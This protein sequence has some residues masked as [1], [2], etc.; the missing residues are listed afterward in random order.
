MK[1]RTLIIM[2]AL[3][4]SALS[5]QDLQQ[6]AD[7]LSLPTE[8]RGSKLHIPSVPGA[9]VS[10]LGADYEQI[11]SPK[12]KIS[13]LPTD[14]PVQVS[15]TLS[16]NGQEAVS[17][18]Y[19]IT[20][21]GKAI[22]QNN[23][24][25]KPRIIPDILSWQGDNGKYTLG[26][27]IILSAPEGPM[28]RNFARELETTTGKKVTL[29]KPGKKNDKKAHIILSPHM[30]D[31]LGK[32]GYR[33]NISKNGIR[34]TAGTETGLFWS[35]RTLL[36]MLVQDSSALPYGKILD[37][38]RYQLRGFMLDIARLPFPMEYLKE[39]VRL[40][41]WYKMNDLHLTINN[42]YIFHEQYVDEGKDPFKESYAAFRLQSKV[43]G[44]TATDLSYTKR[45]F[46]ELIDF[47]RQHGINIVPEFDAPGHALS[48]TRVRP[49]LIYK[50]EMGHA[51]R[52]CEML[53]AANPETLKFLEGIY[54]E[55]LLPQKNKPAVFDGCVMHI[56]ADE[57][58]GGAEHY[59]SFMDGL[60][61]MVQK[62]GYTPR[63]WGSLSAKRGNTP[64]RSEGVQMNLWSEGWSNAWE[65][66]KAGYDV[67]NTNDA[68]L[69]IVPYANYY[70]ADYN[71]KGLYNNWTPNQMY[72][73]TLPAGH[74]QLIGSTFAVWNDMIDQKYNG[75]GAWD[76]W[77]TISGTVD[78]LAQKMWGTATAPTTFEQHREL[79]AK[80][81]HIPG[82]DP[83]FRSTIT[84]PLSLKAKRFEKL[85]AFIRKGSLG[86][87][88]HLTMS[89]EM[90]AAPKNGEEQ[91]LLQSPE[92]TLYAA[93]KDGTIGF[94]R[95]DSMSF[96]FNCKLPVGKRT[97]LELIGTMGK[98]QLLIDGQP[99]GQ[100]TLTRF[101]KR[102]EG[103]MNTFILPLDIVG[104]HFNGTIYSMD[105]TPAAPKQ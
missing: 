53:D 22:P 7:S 93:M 81:N 27:E 36:Q 24:N 10:L 85:P 82:C 11:I 67:I 55:Y 73:Q 16:K 17:K 71:H 60:L 54:D 98:T 44:L 20:I 102:T 26:S 62:K 90:K 25:P 46:R 3:S 94:T 15:F 86:P 100:A 99:T 84:E 105:V 74:P 29:L 69:Y 12:G 65:A 75:Y 68:R 96:S 78:V 5:G 18:D 4:A 9:K 31:D 87:E 49:D 41:A 45:E 89:L 8:I 91:I 14:V 37:F 13:P 2:A 34:I 79:V 104:R 23:A 92:G 43:K 1:K 63:V 19:T 103:L 30:A 83:L 97:K 33:I 57:F 52:R 32:E 6:Q 35:T 42:N 95:S 61:A 21:K 38:P 47:A 80:I 28:A 40:M 51:K 76:I 77:N 101:H 64:V 39:V 72:K 59:R 56:G 48:F 66:V 50:G 88:Y 58:Y 70:R